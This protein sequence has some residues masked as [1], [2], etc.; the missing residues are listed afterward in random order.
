MNISTD[1]IKVSKSA[2]YVFKILSNPLKFKGLMP[3]NLDTFNVA[4]DSEQFEFCLKGLPVIKMKYETK[5]PFKKIEMVSNST[6][7]FK[8][9]FEIEEI[10]ET[11][12]GVEIIFEGNFNPMI[13]MIAKQPLQ[14]FI[15]ILGKNVSEL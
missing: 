3:D 6:I 13:S 1:T 7:Q 5:T 12:S 10:D 15:D 9:C 14:K 4:D 8:L 2:E 11:N